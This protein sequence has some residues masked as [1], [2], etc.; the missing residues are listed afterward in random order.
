MKA[1][2]TYVKYK[3]PYPHLYNISSFLLSFFNY[4]AITVSRQ[5]FVMYFNIKIS[6]KWLNCPL[7]WQKAHLTARPWAVRGSLWR[8]A[9]VS[10]WHPKPVLRQISQFRIEFAT[11]QG[12]HMCF[13]LSI[14]LQAQL[15]VTY[16][17]KQQ[18]ITCRMHTSE[19]H[20]VLKVSVILKR[21]SH[22]S[23]VKSFGAHVSFYQFSN[24][25]AH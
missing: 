6:F 9:H 17:Y 21:K 25:N 14:W 3:N 20:S 1:L 15:Y 12:C 18:Q 16:E 11:V 23:K 4:I 7:H 5:C 8:S 22:M 13:C 24:T 10:L 2:L 19:C